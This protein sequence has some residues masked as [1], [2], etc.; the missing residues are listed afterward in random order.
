MRLGNV[1]RERKRE[2]ALDIAKNTNNR[3]F[4]KITT[5]VLVFKDQGKHED[6]QQRLTKKYSIKQ[7]TMQSKLHRSGNKQWCGL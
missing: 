4:P 3:I 7:S 6:I 2:E 5:W 1:L